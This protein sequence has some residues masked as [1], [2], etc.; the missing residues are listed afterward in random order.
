MIKKARHTLLQAIQTNICTN[1]LYTH[2]GQCSQTEMAERVTAEWCYVDRHHK[3]PEPEDSMEEE[4]VQSYAQDCTNNQPEMYYHLF[5]GR[6]G[7]K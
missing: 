7:R 4:E 1:T 5:H 6:Q 2:T 3:R